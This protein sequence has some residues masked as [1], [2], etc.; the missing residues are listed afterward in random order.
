VQIGNFVELRGAET[1]DPGFRP[2]VA[3][4]KLGLIA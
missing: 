2:I 1:A 4:E 3:I